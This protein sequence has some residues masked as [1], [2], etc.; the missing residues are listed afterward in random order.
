MQGQPVQVVTSTIP[1]STVQQGYVVPTQQTRPL[2]VAVKE[3]RI[4]GILQ[5]VIGCLSVLFGILSVSILRY[6]SGNVGL[7]IWTGLLVSSD[8]IQQ[9]KET[10]FFIFII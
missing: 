10:L 3:T 5:I 1:V 6:W 7:G 2:N 8:M 4:L 9:I